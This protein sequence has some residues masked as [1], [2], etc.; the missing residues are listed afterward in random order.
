MMQRV[1]SSATADALQAGELERA[2]ILFA[3]SLRTELEAEETRLNAAV[4]AD[5]RPPPNLFTPP[6]FPAIVDVW[7]Q[8]APAE[9]TANVERLASRTFAFSDATATEPF[10][11]HAKPVPTDAATLL[12]NSFFQRD[13]QR[14][15]EEAAAGRGLLHREAVGASSC[16]LVAALVQLLLGAPF[17]PGGFSADMLLAFMASLR[18]VTAARAAEATPAGAP[19]AEVSSTTPTEPLDWMAVAA[20]S[21]R[22]LRVALRV[23]LDDD[24]FYEVEED[25]A[26]CWRQARALRVSAVLRALRDTHGGVSLD[27]LR[28]M[29]TWASLRALLA[30]PG[31]TLPVAAALLLFE[32]QRPVFPVCCNA[33]IEVKACGWVP[34][35]AGATAAFLHLNARLPQDATQL[36]VLYGCLCQQNTFRLTRQA[37]VGSGK[38]KTSPADIAYR[39]RRGAYALQLPIL[40]ESADAFDAGDS[41]GQ[42]EGSLSQPEGVLVVAP[43]VDTPGSGGPV[44]PLASAVTELLHHHELYPACGCT[45]LVAALRPV[46]ARSARAAAAALEEGALPQQQR[47]GEGAGL[48]YVIDVPWSA[49]ELE[50]AA[51][52]LASHDEETTTQLRSALCKLAVDGVQPCLFGFGEHLETGLHLAAK[53]NRPVALSVLLEHA[54][55]AVSIR[56]TTGQQ[57]LH[58]A[59]AAGATQ[60]ARI[61][62][63]NNVDVTAA[64]VSGRVPL[65]LA[66]A[67]GSLS[68]VQLLLDH[69][70][71]PNAPKGIAP[72]EA[73]ASSGALDV[74]IVLLEHG[75][76]VD[77][78]DAKNGRT[79]A[80][81]A[82]KAGHL[83]IVRHLVEKHGA[84]LAVRD[85]TERFV[86]EVIPDSV[87][88]DAQWLIDSG[89]AAAKVAPINPAPSIKKDPC[90]SLMETLS[91]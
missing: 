62:L 3:I 82:A 26:G 10:P 24:F 23:G 21:V 61:L 31:I 15:A 25:A 43:S 53:C 18:Q 2:R 5:G 13:S 50:A 1:L 33:L 88:E 75:A 42:V 39:E 7:R 16:N 35:H 73:A 45:P 72:L 64:D 86:H 8:F 11:T 65:S 67:S 14:I 17:A 69:H 55:D 80:H 44:L 76:A 71:T 59:C 87:R 40:L 12:A 38:D 32:L 85:R 49:A 66:A 30:L 74:I 51:L 46:N 4:L 41:D 60:A 77:A 79:A 68:C 90:A 9:R 54:S 36:R 34:P 63:D 6:L 89:K 58:A 27:W 37:L 70:A 78:Q 57:P 47:A 28:P 29:E 19:A 84:S 56:D 48:R 52:L 91:M 83:D 20:L 22:Q 81:A